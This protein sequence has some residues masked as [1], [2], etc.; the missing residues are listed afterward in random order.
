M[1]YGKNNTMP[2]TNTTLDIRL[3]PWRPLKPQ[4]RVKAKLP[5]QYRGQTGVVEEILGS[6]RVDGLGRYGVRM[7]SDE[8]ITDFQRFELSVVAYPRSL[9]RR[10]HSFENNI[11]PPDQT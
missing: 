2:P 8:R 9:K 6:P 1:N 11:S 10:A 5:R 3:Q 4:T 7:D